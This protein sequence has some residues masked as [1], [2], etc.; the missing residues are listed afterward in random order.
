ME[1]PLGTDGRLRDSGDFARDS[2]GIVLRNTQV[3]ICALE[4]QR[5]GAL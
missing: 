1:L 3:S 2:S 4:G 5:I